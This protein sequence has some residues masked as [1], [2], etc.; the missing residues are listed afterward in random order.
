MEVT[1]HFVVD[2]VNCYL[3]LFNNLKTLETIDR[4]FTKSR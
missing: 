2:Y 1:I 3:L 4:R